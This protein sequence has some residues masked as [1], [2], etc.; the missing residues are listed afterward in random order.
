MSHASAD[1]FKE[2]F[3]KIQDELQKFGKTRS[4]GGGGSRKGGVG[5]GEKRRR[6]DQTRS[7][8]FELNTNTREPSAL[9]M[10]VV[11]SA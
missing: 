2:A 4:G 6:K 8:F 5:R 10:A 1:H 3:K 9:L 11:S 7:R